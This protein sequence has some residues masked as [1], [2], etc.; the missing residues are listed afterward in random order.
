MQAVI[1]VWGV[2][3]SQIMRTWV[4][5]IGD[6]NTVDTKRV[7]RF[8]RRLAP[9]LSAVLLFFFGL[10][11]A[12]PLREG[13][14]RCSSPLPSFPV[15]LETARACCLISEKGCQVREFWRAL[16]QVRQ[17]LSRKIPHLVSHAQ[18]RFVAIA[19]RPADLTLIPLRY[20]RCRYLLFD[21][22]HVR[23]FSREFKLGGA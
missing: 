3:L 14:L 21:C 6:E 7:G 8:R 23:Y 11:C 4:H 17:S 12:A 16:P 20:V 2:I 15:W 22:A 1:L 19:S 10:A 18:V 13:G 5:V 9:S